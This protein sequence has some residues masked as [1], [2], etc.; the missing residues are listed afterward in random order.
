MEEIYHHLVPLVKHEAVDETDDA[1]EQMV[2][3]MCASGEEELV[4]MSG[5][6]EGWETFA[7]SHEPE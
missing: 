5:L 7:H 3:M 2:E 1:N 6:H 4:K